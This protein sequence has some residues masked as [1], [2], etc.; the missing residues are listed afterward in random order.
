[1]SIQANNIQY[2]SG[3]IQ[4][5]SLV[6]DSK[7]F[8]IQYQDGSYNVSSSGEATGESGAQ[9]QPPTIVGQN[10]GQGASTA[11]ASTTGTTGTGTTGTGT[12][13]TGTTGTGTTGTGTAGT[14]TSTTIETT[15][16]QNDKKGKKTISARLLNR[17]LFKS[18]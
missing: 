15:E 3:N 16:T 11:T 10:I 8:Q 13:G 5:C 2:S 12:T 9:P 17:E 4:T 7:V 14:G 18:K 1:M 6:I